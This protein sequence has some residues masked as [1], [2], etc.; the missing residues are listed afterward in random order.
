MARVTAFQAV[1]RG[2]ESR[3]PLKKL[4]YTVYILKSAKAE[5]CYIGSTENLRDRLA[6][7]NSAKARWTKRFQP[8]DVVHTEV[9]ETRGEA[10]RRE[11][12]L[13]S[14]KGI[15]SQIQEIKE[16]KL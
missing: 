14:L 11:K 9:F 3:L 12:F 15:A 10:L 4:S 1:G 16:G 2:F 7:H 13:K 5:R 6:V 8:W